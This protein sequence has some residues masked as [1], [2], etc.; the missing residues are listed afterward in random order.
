MDASSEAGLVAL[1]TSMIGRDEGCRLTAYRDT[2]GIWTI[3]WGRADAGVTEGMKCTQAEA[4]AWRARKIA[5]VITDLDD[6]EPWWRAMDGVRQ[7][8]FV[9]MAYELG[10]HGLMAFQRMLDACSGADWERAAAEML[11]SKWAS[12]VPNRAR[13]L[14]DQMRTGTAQ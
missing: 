9:D 2:R 7:A 3:A 6:L 12:Q 14:A 8:V 10:A 1:A 5:D 13:R 11:N 4:D